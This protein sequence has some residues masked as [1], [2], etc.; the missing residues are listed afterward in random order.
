MGYGYPANW[1][2]LTD[3]V[4]QFF[5]ASGVYLVLSKALPAHETFLKEAILGDESGVTASMEESSTDQGGGEK[6]KVNVLTSPVN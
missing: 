1:L 3:A 5:S 4:L 2:T 6:E